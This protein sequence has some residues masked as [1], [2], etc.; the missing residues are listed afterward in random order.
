MEARLIEIARSAGRASLENTQEPAADRR[1]LPEADRA[2]MEAF[3]AN[4]RIILPIVGLELLKPQ[5]QAAATSGTILRSGEGKFEIRHKSGVTATAIEEDGEFV[6]LAGSS[7]LKNAGYQHNSYSAL[8][9]QLIEQSII[10]ETEDG[11]A[12]KFTSP[13]AFQSPSAAAA[14]IL[15]RNSNGRNEWK[16]VGEKRSYDDW[17]REKVSSGEAQK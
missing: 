1:R 11:S 10:Q 5:P 13:Y 17:Q 9:R 14:I 4:L 6:V 12:Y 3:L 16:V 8:K 15:D 7:A 2:N